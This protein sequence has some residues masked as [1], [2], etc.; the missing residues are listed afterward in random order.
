M[1]LYQEGGEE[2]NS[3][4]GEMRSILQIILLQGI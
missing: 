2:M 1:I 3:K 4:I